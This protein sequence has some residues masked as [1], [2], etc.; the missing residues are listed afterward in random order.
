M[1]YLEEKGNLFNAN[2]KYYLCHCIASD[3]RMG[4]GI[5][6]QFIKNYPYVKSLRKTINDVGTCIKIKRVL[7][8]I[9]KK[10]SHGKP[11]Y[12]ILERSLI[13]C[14]NI[15]V[16]ENIKFLAMPKIGCGL[17]GLQWENVKEIIKTTFN[18]TDIEIKVYKL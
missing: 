3:A 8:L 9:T 12:Q 10:V 18:D 6:V 1:I 15:C 17:D 13:D 16:K 4:A 14:K 5:A 7:N 2:K 11:T